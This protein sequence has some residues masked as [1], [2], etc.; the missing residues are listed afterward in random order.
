MRSTACGHDVIDQQ[1]R[2]V[3][4]QPGRAE[5]KC[6]LHRA[7]SFDQAHPGSMSPGRLDANQARSVNGQSGLGSQ[8]FSDHFSLIEGAFGH[9]FRVERHWQYRINGMKCLDL[10]ENCDHPHLQLTRQVGLSLQSQHALFHRA[11]VWTAGPRQIEGQ[12]V[13][14]PAP[15]RPGDEQAISTGQRDSAFGAD[16]FMQPIQVERL[17]AIRTGYS[18]AQ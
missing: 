9:T 5:L 18:I 10:P 7:G 3:F 2:P 17:P 4:N 11:M 16:L 13:A 8:G 14:T 6:I 15:A 12:L 1:D